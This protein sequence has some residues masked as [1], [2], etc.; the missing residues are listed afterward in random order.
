MAY[1]PQP[2]SFEDFVKQDP[3]PLNGAIKDWFAQF[4]DEGFNFSDIQSWKVD[5]PTEKSVD[6]PVASVTLNMKNKTFHRDFYA[7]ELMGL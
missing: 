5:F 1:L 2:P 7:I 3:T 6:I 4:Y